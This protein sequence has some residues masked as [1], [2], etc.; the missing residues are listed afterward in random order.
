MTTIEADPTEQIS[1]DPEEIT[2]AIL[3]QLEIMEKEKERKRLKHNEYM[4][5]YYRTKKGKANMQ[6]AQKKWYKPHGKKG[7]PKK[8]ISNNNVDGE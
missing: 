3:K 8:D 2:V 4:R 5:N 6:K 7:R 1:P